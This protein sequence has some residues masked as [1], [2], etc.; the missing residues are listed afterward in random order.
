MDNLTKEEKEVMAFIKDDPV[1]QPLF[2]TEIKGL[3]WFFPLQE[4]G[5]FNS[6]NLPPPKSSEREGYTIIP[7]W[8]AMDYL[9]KTA[10]E[11]STEKG[12][13]YHKEFL[14]IVENATQYAKKNEFSNYQV[15]WRFAKILVYISHNIMSYKTIDAV[16]YWLEDKYDTD[17]VAQIIG[18]KLLPKLLNEQNKDTTYVASELLSKLFKV[19]FK[20]HPYT[21]KEKWQQAHLRFNNYWAKRIIEAVAL[22]T[23]KLLKKEGVNIFHNKLTRILKKLKKDS[24]SSVW[25]PAIENHDQNSLH[26]DAEN[27]LVLAYRDSL[28]GF[29][30]SS[31]EEAKKYLREMLHSEYQTIQRIAIYHI[32]KNP[33]LYE[34]LWNCIIDEKFFKENLRHETWQ[35]LNLN[36]Q[37]FSNKQKG[38]TL[39]IIEKITRKGE[40]G[41]I[42][43]EASAYT[44][45]NWLAAIKDYG[46]NE[47]IFHQ[48]EVEAAGGESEHPSFSIYIT[49]GQAE[50]VHPSS[51]YTLKELNEMEITDLVEELKSFKGASGWEEP[52]VFGLS[53]SFKD[54]IVFNPLHY[55]EHLDEFKDL[56]LAYV[57]SVISAYSDLWQKKTNFIWDD[58]WHH[59]LQYI[60]KVLERENFWD[61]N[62]NNNDGRNKYVS[63][64]NDVVK[65][66]STLIKGKT[67]SDDD[68]FNKKHYSKVKDILKYLLKNQ[69]GDPFKKDENLDAL[70]MA[71]NSPR[72]QCLETLINVALQQCRLADKKNDGDHTKAWKEFQPYFDA[73]LKQKSDVNYEFFALLPRRIPNFLY[74]SENWLMKNLEV[75]F[76]QNDHKKWT[77]AIHGY[78]Y[79]NRFN[80][81]VYQ[82]LKSHEHIN[83]ALNDEDLPRNCSIRF[84]QNAVYSFLAGKERLEDE[85]SLIRILL[86]R[87]KSYEIHEVIRFICSFRPEERKKI[88]PKVYELWTRVQEIVRKIGFS[89]DEGRKLVSSLCQWADFLDQIDNENK[90]WLL[91]I[92][93]YVHFNHSSHDFLE[94]LARISERDPF[95]VNEILQAMIYGV[96]EHTY[97]FTGSDEQ[98]K[99]ILESLVDKGKEKGKREAKET[100]GKFA[101][102]GIFQPSK[103]L[104]EILNETQTEANINTKHQ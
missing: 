1:L 83:R 90:E 29:I 102:K 45:S 25:Q 39:D 92:A 22:K 9:V 71:I 96:S 57:H 69:K 84:V 27:L 62:E 19:S 100:V 34:K 15:W 8:E 73:E 59:L 97:G 42:L 36:Y 33:K 49:S 24:Y 10:P 23:G 38:N 72:G 65:A 6:E 14:S 47:K 12:K 52:S 41:Y 81:E 75:I 77:C 44:R 70:T 54:A 16:D 28:E 99:T 95:E 98:I 43:K 74:M 50:I 79:L 67:Q 103:I 91:E 17:L 63:N 87:G 56:D 20:P 64:R 5:Y 101:K 35:F 7:L 51:P 37:S 46:E 66:I 48:K 4:K 53:Q 89:S 94:N 21:F 61:T 31:H 26:D 58:V 88:I 3:K 104:S 30:Q 78:A 80:A 82:Y 55:S 11:L 32:G 93:P 76:D 13:L 68:A 86:S 2:F 60:L 18:E 40:N 85:D